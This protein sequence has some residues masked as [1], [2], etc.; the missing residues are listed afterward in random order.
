MRPPASQSRFTNQNCS[1]GSGLLTRSDSA[2][3]TMITSAKPYFL[4]EDISNINREIKEVLQSGHLVRGKHLKAF[5]D[6]VCEYT[7][8]RYVLA[9]NS[10][11][12]ALIIAL[13]ALDVKE[14]EVIVPTNTFIA[15]P[16]AVVFAGGKPVFADINLQ[17]YCLDLDR[18]KETLT[19]ETAGIIVVHMAGILYPQIREL[20]KL[21]DERRLFL[22]ED[23]AHS[24]GAMIDKTMVGH[25][26]EIACYSCYPTKII[27]TGE[28]GIITTNDKRLYEFCK[29]FNFYGHHLENVYPFEIMGANYRMPEI[30][31]ILG[32]YQLNRVEFFIEKRRRIAEAYS[33]G[34]KELGFIQ[35]QQPPPN[36]RHVYY[37]YITLVE[38]D[39][40]AMEIM[41]YLQDH[42]IMAD[43]DFYPPCHSQPIYRDFFD[44][45]EFP[46]ANELQRHLLLLPMHAQL[47]LDEVEKVLSCLREF[48]KQRRK[49]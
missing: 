46:N 33:K 14:K 42:G 12:S 24:F 40:D 26:G 49:V 6:A 27:T 13:F 47:T 41:R 18:V 8:C 15:T 4:E 7:Q 2:T 19:S 28:G 31:A 10:G 36:I 37:K 3:G 38:E 23:A 32:R 5:E 1:P 39:Y 34:L 20:R 17:D 21:C 45:S 9:T 30:S 48:A 43:R 11:T 29:R 35:H 22:L 44:D 25:F 16:N